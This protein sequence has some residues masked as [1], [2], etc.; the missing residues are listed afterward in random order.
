MKLPADKKARLKLF[1]AIG[2][3]TAVAV[4]AVFAGVLGPMSR[5]KKERRQAIQDLDDKLAKARAAV[6]RFEIDRAGNSNVLSEIVNTGVRQNMVLRDRLGNFLLGAS[7]VIETAAR[8]AGV[9][10]EPPTEVGMSQIPQG[11]AKKEATAFKAYTV[12]I[13]TQCGTH[14][15]IRLLSQVETSNPYLCVS[16]LAITGQPDKPDKHSV[17]MDVQWPIWGD[18][19]T[20][21]NLEAQLKAIAQTESAPQRTTTPAAGT[22]GSH[23]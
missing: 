3:G 12:H 10:I 18:P 1:A 17:A 2:V 8:Q 21:A 5:I 16:S 13:A 19:E 4:Y 9:P 23:R 6:E 22:G 15:L 11:S 20:P 14:D 7:E